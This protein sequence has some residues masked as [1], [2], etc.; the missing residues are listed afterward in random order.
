LSDGQDLSDSQQEPT[1]VIAA[2]EDA[3]DEPVFK[4]AVRVL[5][6]AGDRNSWRSYGERAALD[7]LAGNQKG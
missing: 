6:V 4:L 3:L 7:G 2:I 1:E 5:L